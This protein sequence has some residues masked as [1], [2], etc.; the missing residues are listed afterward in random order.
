MNGMKRSSA[1]SALR[2]GRRRLAAMTSM[3]MIAAAFALVSAPAASAAPPPG[4][5]DNGFENAG[6]VAV[7][8]PSNA[9]DVM[10]NVTRETSGTDGIPSSAGA[11]YAQTVPAL[12][13]GS[14]FTRY[15]GY[16]SVF[17]LGG[18]TTSID[19]YLDMADSDVGEDTRFDWSS[20]IN[21][22]DGN[23]QRDFIF[24][25]GTDGFGD[26]VMSASNNTPGWPANPGR[27]PLTVTTTGWYTF[28]HTFRDDGTGVLAVDMSVLDASGNVLKTWTLSDPADIIGTEVGGNR[29]GSFFNNGFSSLAIDDIT[30]S[31]T[32]TLGACAVATTVD[33]AVVTYTLLGD[34]TTDHTVVVPQNPGAGNSSVFDGAGFSITG[35]DPVGDHFKG[36]V[37]QAQAG[38]NPITV[39]NLTVQTSNLATVCDGGAD[40]LRGIL[41]DAVPGTITNNVV[42]NIEQGATGDGCQEGNAIEARNEP[43]DKSGTDDKVVT[44]TNNV[45]TEYQKSGIVTN[46][47]VAATIKNNSVTGDGPINYI[48]QNGIQVGFGATA[49]VR[50]NSSSGNY[51]TPKS[52]LACGFLI[53]QAGGVSASGNNFFD[54]E[55]NQCNF[56]KG[57][58]TYKP[59]T[60]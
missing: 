34:C 35:V 54:N 49:V 43:F 58:G 46:G 59:S 8:P 28:Q 19:I 25:V 31:G 1:F 2:T 18:Y 40:R 39:T 27:T 60:P 17:P 6:D 47:S 44:I 53:Y 12:G 10:F 45:M 36:A 38:S 11:H 16:S 20:A 50:M 42:T 32:T 23:H 24:S 55:R 14:Q 56:G 51:Y 37:V 29:Y 7:R 30:R 4:S 9:N 21:G 41:F 13:D 26:F 52:D 15:G 22:T 33:G 5:Y 48:A 57:G 3:A